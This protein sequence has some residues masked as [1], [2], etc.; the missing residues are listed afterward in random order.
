MNKYT[1]LHHNGQRTGT[2][3]K[4]FIFC[5]TPTQRTFTSVPMKLWKN[6]S[7]NV[8]TAFDE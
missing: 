1:Y 7:N 4:L 5:Y 6:T 8:G 2:P 3:Q